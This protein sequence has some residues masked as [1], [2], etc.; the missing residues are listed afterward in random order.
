MYSN[1][2]LVP[3]RFNP[4]MTKP[5]EGGRRF[6]LPLRAADVET[7]VTIGRMTSIQNALVWRW[8]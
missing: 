8:E 7:K 4:T 3:I 6:R 5:D 2:G 1:K